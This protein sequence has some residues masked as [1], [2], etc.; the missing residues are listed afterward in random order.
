M[1]DV[2]VVGEVMIYLYSFI[3]FIQVGVFKERGI[4]VIYSDAILF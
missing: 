1:L 3:F 4:G 2:D